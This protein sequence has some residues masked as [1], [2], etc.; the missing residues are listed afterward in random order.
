MNPKTSQVEFVFS[1]Y[2]VGGRSRL[3]MNELFLLL[4]STSAGLCKLSGID[5]PDSARLESIAS[6]VREEHEAD[7][8]PRCVVEFFAVWFTMLDDGLGH[9]WMCGHVAHSASSGFER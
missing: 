8:I 6:L 7:P 4:K 9:A 1:C 3:S 5:A 2:D